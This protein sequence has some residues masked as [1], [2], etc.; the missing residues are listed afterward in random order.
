MSQVSGMH[1]GIVVDSEDPQ[2]SGRLKVALAATAVAGAG[3][4][5]LW[6]QVLGN[7]DDV[8]V[9]ASF[10]IG[11]QL[12]VLVLGGGDEECFVLGHVL[13]AAGE[14][15]RSSAPTSIRIVDEEGRTSLEINAPVGHRVELS[16]S[17]DLP[18]TGSPWITLTSRLPLSL[19]APTLAI[20]ADKVQLHA[21][22][23]QFAGSVQ[24]TTLIADAVVAASYSPGAGN[25]S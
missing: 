22:V 25:I 11:S 18:S 5:E 15:R 9:P 23:V 3:R 10:P 6:A 7:W 8:D 21:P 19:I 12:L 14:L 24:C 4:E 20:S 1:R 16:R 17:G 13:G 2:H